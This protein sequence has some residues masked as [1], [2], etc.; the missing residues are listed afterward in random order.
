MKFHLYQTLNT[1]G[2]YHMAYFY[3]EDTLLQ[4][5]EHFLVVANYI[6]K[7]SRGALTSLLESVIYKFNG[8]LFIP[9]QSFKL[10]GATKWLPIKVSI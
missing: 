1:H 8:N 9:F 6:G 10:L 3:L 4:E 2:A 7:N 5:S